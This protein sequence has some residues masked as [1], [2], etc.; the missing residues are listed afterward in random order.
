MNRVQAEII[1]DHPLFRF[2]VHRVPRAKRDILVDDAVTGGQK[3]IQ[4]ANQVVAGVVL[5][6]INMGQ[7]K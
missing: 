1:D 3:V 5:I 7:L 6:D 4:Q 2:S